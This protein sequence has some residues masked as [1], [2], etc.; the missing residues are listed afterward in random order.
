M[1]PFAPPAFAL[2]TPFRVLPEELFLSSDL[3]GDD[4]GVPPPACD[5]VKPGDGD[6][7]G[8]DCCCCCCK[9]AGGTNEAFASEGGVLVVDGRPSKLTPLS[10]PIEPSSNFTKERFQSLVALGEYMT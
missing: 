5:C 9:Y 2:V 6:G 7:D 1:P 3:K 4:G 8:D 10:S